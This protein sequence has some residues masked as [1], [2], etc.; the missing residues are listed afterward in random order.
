MTDKTPRPVTEVT[1]IV[2]LSLPYK[3]H[4]VVITAEPHDISRSADN[5]CASREESFLGDEGFHPSSRHRV[6]VRSGTTIVASRVLMAAGGASGVHTHSAFIRDDACFLAVGPFVCALELPALR[7]L[8]HACADTATCFGVYDAP[9]YS[10]LISHGELEIA[11][12]SYSGELLWSE[13]GRDIFSEGFELHAG[14]AE[15]IDFN[16]V[17][18]RFDLQTGRSMESPG[19]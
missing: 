18:Y 16:G 12:F 8:W 17:R 19:S 3:D 2:H 13:S 15:A 14:H 11:R 9:G 5:G 6:V 4:E 1:L 7:L 10:S